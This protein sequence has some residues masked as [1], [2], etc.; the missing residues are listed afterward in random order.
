MMKLF[1]KI[2]SNSLTD[3][4]EIVC[5]NARL[6]QTQAHPCLAN[7]AHVFKKLPSLLEEVFG[8]PKVEQWQWG[9]IHQHSYKSIPFTD[10]PVL[11]HIWGRK[12]PAGG[13]SRTVNVGITT[14]QTKSY[15]SLGGPVFRFI[16]DLNRTI[17]TFDTGNSAN[18]FSPYYDN[19]VGKDEYIEYERH[20]P[21]KEAVEG[22]TRTVKHM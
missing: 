21:L 8:T 20:N 1:V 12:T 22:W 11:K 6:N 2:G 14:Y 13:N 19:F 3:E 4:E 16:S 7:A 5:A 10:L 17:F 9:T 18:M 15:E